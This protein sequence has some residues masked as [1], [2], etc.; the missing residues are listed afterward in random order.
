MKKVFS[1]IKKISPVV[2]IVLAF[3][4]A[5][6]MSSF[7]TYSICNSEKQI[8]EQSLDSI[9]QDTIIRTQ[10]LKFKYN[11]Q[12]YTEFVREGSS[13]I[14]HDPEYN[15]LRSKLNN[16]T[17]V[18]TNNTNS[19][20][21]KLDQND[22]ANFRII[23]DKLTKLENDIASLKNASMKSNKKVIK[24]QRKQLKKK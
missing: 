1:F 24:V 8:T 23:I 4:G 3:C 15:I 10:V 18:I 2:L 14:V 5:I 16:I 9:G 13:Y 17:T 22:R 11:N 19:E 21:S 20:I 7:I 6:I 12:E